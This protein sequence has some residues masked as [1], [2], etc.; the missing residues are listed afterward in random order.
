MRTALLDPV[1]QHQL[2]FSIFFKVVTGSIGFIGSTTLD[3]NGEPEF[4]VSLLPSDTLH[5][6]RVSYQSMSV[7]WV[8]YKSPTDI[9]WN[10][11]AALSLFRISRVLGT[12]ESL[13]STIVAF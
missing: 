2:L 5:Q 3:L 6:I 8:Q 12:S 4:P 7:A 13:I 11:P 10:T 1:V 9:L